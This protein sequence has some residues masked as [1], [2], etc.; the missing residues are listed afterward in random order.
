[1]TRY[2]LVFGGRNMGR[3]LHLG[4]VLLINQLES[5][6]QK[7]EMYERFLE[8][9]KGFAENQ[10]MLDHIPRTIRRIRNPGPNLDPHFHIYVNEY[11][12]CGRRQCPDI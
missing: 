1:M 7:M 4:R 5:I 9:Q 11:C 2:R 12:S 3:S 6:Q 8:V 10:S